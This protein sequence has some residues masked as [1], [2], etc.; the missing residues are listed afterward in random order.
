MHRGRIPVA[1]DPFHARERRNRKLASHTALLPK[2][3]TRLGGL[4]E[5]II[6]LYADGMT[7]RDIGHRLGG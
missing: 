7:V 5:I 4:S 1:V 3:E 2:H 6:S